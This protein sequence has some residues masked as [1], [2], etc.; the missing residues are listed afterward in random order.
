[1]ACD[2]IAIL[3]IM[4]YL[5]TLLYLLAIIIGLIKTSTVNIQLFFLIGSHILEDLQMVTANTHWSLFKANLCSLWK[6]KK[7]FLVSTT[8]VIIK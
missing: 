6:V 3:S 4:K 1:M 7:V 5:K 8:L 2:G